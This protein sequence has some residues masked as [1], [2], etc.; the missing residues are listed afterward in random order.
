MA[1][2]AGRQRMLTPPFGH[3]VNPWICMSDADTSCE[4]GHCSLSWLFNKP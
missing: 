4:M 1:G 2:V 3:M